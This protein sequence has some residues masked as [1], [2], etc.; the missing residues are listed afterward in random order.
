MPAASAAGSICAQVQNG[1]SLKGVTLFD[2]PPS[3]QASLAPDRMRR[4]TGGNRSEWNV[5]EVA[6]SDRHLFV[7]CDYGPKSPAVVLQQPL[8]TATCALTSGRGQL[9]LTCSKR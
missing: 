8:S 5:A 7:R 3:D 6:R 9:T 1:N 4:V 2:R